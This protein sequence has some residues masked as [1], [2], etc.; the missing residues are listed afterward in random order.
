MYKI[1]PRRRSERVRSNSTRLA[2][3]LPTLLCTTYDYELPTGP[4]SWPA[5]ATTSIGAVT[6]ELLCAA[7]RRS[8]FVHER[9]HFHDFVGTT[10][11]MRLFFDGQRI[12]NQFLVNC[13]PALE[14]AR[15][16]RVPL[17]DWTKMNDCPDTIARFVREYTELSLDAAWVAADVEL[18]RTYA[19]DEAVSTYAEASRFPVP[20]LKFLDSESQYVPLGGYTLEEGAAFVIENLYLRKTFGAEFETLYNARTR[21][22]PGG[23]DY[24]AALSYFFATA[25]T[26]DLDLFLSACDYS[27]NVSASDDT[28][29]AHP[30][31]RFVLFS[32]QLAWKRPHEQRDAIKAVVERLARGPGWVPPDK[33]WSDAVRYCRE[34]VAHNDDLLRRTGSVIGLVN[35][36]YY[37]MALRVFEKRLSGA[38]RLDTFRSYVTSLR[39]F[40]S[41]PLSRSRRNGRLQL[42]L[43]PGQL[44]DEIIGWVQW[45]HLWCA[46]GQLLDGDGLCC[47]QDYGEG[48]SPDCHL[49]ANCNGSP[50][51]SQCTYGEYL[52]TLGLHRVTFECCA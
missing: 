47:L 18:P 37:D 23:H 14:R 25:Q 32:E 49:H 43:I 46:V 26:R 40:P 34:Q 7:L 48:F 16:V 41:P 20:I 19:S 42:S 52:R 5:A 15:V 45:I 3:F 30:G 1:W 33:T 38:I 4:Q 9:R 8:A 21:T 13:L 39:E 36:R 35:Q 12:L 44:P 6:E 50:Q 29:S 22:L 51:T 27:L 2:Y 31:W 17:V 24:L 11:G 28:R 10:Y